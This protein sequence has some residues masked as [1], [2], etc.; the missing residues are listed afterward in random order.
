M[1]RRWTTSRATGWGAL[2][3]LAA[4]L[5]WIPYAAYQDWAHW[6]YFAAVAVTALCG[7]SILWITGRDILR[8]GF[9]GRWLAPI[10][11]FDLAMG[12]LL[13]APSLW[14]LEGLLP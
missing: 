8:R 3:A 5:L 13:T 4:I 9:R 1:T 10:R 2:A 14:V 12:L 11:T 7:L 6:P